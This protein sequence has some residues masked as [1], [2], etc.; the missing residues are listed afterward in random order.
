MEISQRQKENELDVLERASRSNEEHIQRLQDEIEALQRQNSELIERLEVSTPEGGSSS[1]SRM[2]MESVEVQER[3]ENCEGKLNE[4]DAEIH[5]L[6]LRVQ[7]LARAVEMWKKAAESKHE[8]GIL[9]AKKYQEAV[10]EKDEKISELE[11]TLAETRERSQKKL[12]EFGREFEEKLGKSIEVVRQLELEIGEKDRSR[13]VL[14]K[15]MGDLELEVQKLKMKNLCQEETFE[16][17]KQVSEMQRRAAA[18]SMESRLSVATEEMR[19]KWAASKREMIGMFIA[20]FPEFADLRSGLDEKS[21]CESIQKVK[22]AV[23]KWKGREHAIRKLVH[24][25][26]GE[27]IDDALTRFIITNDPRLRSL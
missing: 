20:A 8:G 7:T 24:A 14:R 11:S 1:A 6:S 2:L 23:E 3:A 27:S 19:Q 10:S 16:R 26:E 15:G 9:S 17:A 25:E 13:Q 18:M 4:K 12:E 21:Y 22:L 5:S